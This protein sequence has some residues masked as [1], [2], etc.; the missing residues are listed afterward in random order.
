MCSSTV[1]LTTVFAAITAPYSIELPGNTTTP[2]PIQTQS[3]ITIGFELIV[4]FLGG[5]EWRVVEIY[6]WNTMIVIRDY[7]I[8]S[9]QYILSNIN[10]IMASKMKIVTKKYYFV[11]W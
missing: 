8:A 10:R 1:P 2:S 7:N 4:L 6:K 3:A 5:S 9:N 11:Q